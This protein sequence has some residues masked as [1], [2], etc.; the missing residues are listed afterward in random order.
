MI[1]ARSLFGCNM[2]GALWVFGPG[3]VGYNSDESSRVL[4]AKTGEEVGD[5]G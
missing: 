3:S 5:D 2:D 4:G 1:F